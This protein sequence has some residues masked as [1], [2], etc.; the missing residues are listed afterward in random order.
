MNALSN[1][2]CNRTTLIILG[3]CLVLAGPAMLLWASRAPVA[4]PDGGGPDAL[5]D[6]MEVERISH[7]QL[8]HAT[9]RPEGFSP[10]GQAFKNGP[11][12]AQG[13]ATGL[14][15][16]NIGDLD[17][18]N[19]EALLSSLPA[20]LRLGEK[21]KIGLGP[22]GSLTPGLNYAML[23]REAL[24]SKS[25]DAIFEGIRTSARIISVGQNSTLMLYVAAGQIGQLRQNQDVAYFQAVP[26]GDKIALNTARTPLIES[27]R[28]TDPNL[29]LEVA[30]VP[31]SD[32]A[33]ARQEISRVPGIVDVADYGPGGSTLLVR[34]DYKALGRL[35]RVKDVLYLQESLEKMTLNARNVPA[36]QVGTDQLSNQAR[37]FDDAGLDGGG[38]GALLCTQSPVRTCATNNDCTNN[39]QC[40]AAGNPTACCTGA[41]TGTCTGPFPGG[42]CALQKYNNGTAAVPPQIVGVLDNGISADTPSF[43]HTATLV[44]D[45]THPFGPA[46]R[47]IHSIIAVRD[48]GSD[49]DSI[50]HGSGSHG[51]IVASVIGAWPTGVG[52][53]PSRSGIGS[54][55]VPRNSNL[56]GVA[57]GAR[58]IVSDIAD[59]SR[60]TF[61][62]LVERGGNVDPGSLATRLAELI[63]PKTGGAGACAN[64]TGGGT[65]VHLAVTP[66]GAPDNFSTIQFQQNDGKY[67]QESADIDTFLYN[68]RD[69]LVFGPA[70][71]SGV[72]ISSSRPDFWTPRVIPDMFDGTDLDDCIQPPNGSCDPAL[73]TPRPIQIPPPMTAKNIVTVGVTRADEDTFFKNFDNLANMATYSSRGPA[74]KESRRM[75]PV[76]RSGSWGG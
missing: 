75:A 65:E 11:A 36:V 72:L 69:F 74:T 35:A 48:N 51:N 63:C 68:N 44:T 20:E 6:Q 18:K 14:L 21:E 42:V 73:F 60:C 22:K 32:F 16:M 8:P 13:E 54:A 66:F 15:R 17:P 58:I 12:R 2:K 64:I 7:A 45:G 55:S 19:P 28:A 25:L 61:N 52:A 41:G 10:F 40:V 38:S 56:D 29:L 33:D 34:A 4:L 43:A 76:L 67:L 53:F 1:I 71:N 9:L 46:H 70:G 47:K 62:S 57:R 24:S 23:S 26:A 27:A 59:S 31:G 50:L 37:P 5:M 30:L 3:L 39:S 49:C